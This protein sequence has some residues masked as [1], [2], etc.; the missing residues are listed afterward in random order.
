MVVKESGAPP[1]QEMPPKLENMRSMSKLLTSELEGDKSMSKDDSDIFFLK[2]KA[3]T[4]WE[5]FES[6]LSSVEGSVGLWLFP[7]LPESY[8]LR[9]KLTVTKTTTN[10]WA[11][12][13]SIQITLIL[14]YTAF[15]LCFSFQSNLGYDTIQNLYRA[16]IAVTQVFVLDFALFFYMH[17]STSW[18]Y[19]TSGNTIISIASLIPT[20]LGLV[21]R[22]NNTTLPM[23]LVTLNFL[24]CTRVL[25]ILKITKSMKYIN[26]LSGLRRQ[27]FYLT[28]SVS[29]M[30]ILATGLVFLTENMVE[31]CR[32]INAATNWEPSCS[33][34]S[35]SSG[36][37]NC[38]LYDCGP[39]YNYGDKYGEPSYLMCNKMSRLDSFYYIIVTVATIG[40]GDVKVTNPIA[41]AVTIIFIGISV[42]LIPMRLSELQ[43]ILS[44]S[45]PYSRPFVRQAN[46]SHIIITGFTSDK[47]KLENF[48]SE[49]F[50]PDRTAQEAEECH[51]VILSPNTPSE[52]IRSLLQSHALESKVTWV[53]GS[54]SSIASLKKV[55]ADT[56]VAMFFLIDSDL[57]DSQTRSED[58]ANVLSALSVSNFNSAIV[59]FVQVI[60]PEN[61]DILQDS[62][63]DMI[64][65]LDE[66]KTAIQARNSVC[67]GFTTFIENVF[68]SMGALD[69]DVEK[70]MAPWYDEYLHGAGMEIYFV[71]LT[72]H[73][74]RVMR[75]NYLRIVDLVYIKW[76]CTV[77]GLCGDDRSEAIFNPTAKD[78]RGFTSVKSL[79]ESFDVLIIMADDQHIAEDIQLSLASNH[80]LYDYLSDAVDEEK[81]F[82]CGS[83]Q[84]RTLKKFR[85]DMG[86]S[87]NTIIGTLSGTASLVRDT[88][89]SNLVFAN[90]D[91][92]SDSDDQAHFQVKTKQLDSTG[93]ASPSNILNMPS[94]SDT[95]KEES[96]GD[97]L[98]TDESDDDDAEDDEAKNYVGYTDKTLSK[99]YQVTRFMS[100]SSKSNN[101]LTNLTTQEPKA[102]P[103]ND[104]DD[105]DGEE[106]EEL[107]ED[108]EEDDDSDYYDSDSDE[109][110]DEYR[111]YDD[112]AGLR[113]D[114]LRA[115]EENSYG[116]PSRVVKDA[117]NLSDHIIVHGGENQI[118]IF[119][120][121]L[122]KPL[123]NGDIYHPVVIVY[124]KVPR[125]WSHIAELYNDVYLLVG[126]I[127]SSSV[128]KRLNFKFAFS[129]A[130]MAQRSTMTKVDEVNVNIGTLFTYLKLERYIPRSLHTTVELSS[131]SNMGVLNA[132]IMRRYQDSLQRQILPIVSELQVGSPQ[133]GKSANDDPRRVLAPP[134]TGGRIAPLVSI[135]ES[136]APETPTKS[137]LPPSRR[138]V[139]LNQKQVREQKDAAATK[140]QV[141][142]PQ[143]RAAITEGNG[144]FATKRSTK[145]ILP[146]QS[147]SRPYLGVST[148]PQM[149]LLTDKD[150]L[151]T[152][153]SPPR[154]G[155]TLE[156]MTDAAAA[157][158][159]NLA[160]EVKHVEVFGNMLDTLNASDWDA[161][162]THYVLP[163]F[164]SAK[165]FVPSS[166]ES[167]IVQSFYEKL[168]PVICDKFVCGQKAQSMRSLK[169]PPTLARRKYIDLFRL[170]CA[171]NVIC[172]AIY[173]APQKNLGSVLPYVV[174]NPQPDMILSSTD[175]SIVFADS[176]SLLRFKIAAR[177]VR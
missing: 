125:S 89:K 158:I 101:Q 55:Q 74:L 135:I 80:K 7:S 146:G 173:R 115:T 131:P 149:N 100:N 38:D 4:I 106:G 16:D 37:C 113:L 75:Y 34:Y 148:Q 176:T 39:Y 64:L 59:S 172:V 60:R 79:F 159:T 23:I 27:V 153:K 91:S 98:F 1:L 118:V 142:K 66:Y 138:T 96:E 90:D 141:A 12:Y 50:H 3:N 21:D 32:Y 85:E 103:D 164:A 6:W 130:L 165:V 11:V 156:L 9:K 166:F 108:E 168:T 84:D 97:D 65:C 15:F 114:L 68:H 124:D 120:E 86:N 122:R 58:A 47:R 129:L 78:V 87:N 26:N 51:A 19:L 174:T 167:L 133:R 170:F 22:S 67:P 73:F 134:S 99:N 88:S 33:E 48:L 14:V 111:D 41:R 112:D 30:I 143:R 63:V 132:T 95:D 43:N 8:S 29:I 24:K 71:K 18:S 82:P 126:K 121:E 13:D 93:V 157:A 119:I 105:K 83:G 70:T 10:G 104:H 77:L 175:L 123:V 52:D 45:N 53:L 161:M 109:D 36:D 136:P 163:V 155:S 140:N 49:F 76:G 25:L 144:R 117:M 46:E 139:V 2:L 5:V 127:T 31:G 128:L 28:L 151:S 81:R 102:S 94:D 145:V 42:V 171:N 20:Y 40:Y 177:Q 116:R 69:S 169:I 137:D 35:P 92:D 72:P 150:F 57:T 162:E 154:R 62:D 44:L 61:G 110:D 152:K 17:P 56:A 160:E 54:P 107:E 147:S